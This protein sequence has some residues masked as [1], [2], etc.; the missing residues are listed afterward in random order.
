MRG[1]RDRDLLLAVGA[2]S[3]VSFTDEPVDDSAVDLADEVVR[4]RSFRVEL[5]DESSRL[6]DVPDLAELVG[7]G[8][9]RGLELLDIG[10]L[11][12]IAA[13]KLLALMLEIG[14]IFRMHL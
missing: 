10:S 4:R 5:I 14:L 7:A 2:G 9:R 8:R 11:F 3:G 13:T 12:F 6:G 1:V